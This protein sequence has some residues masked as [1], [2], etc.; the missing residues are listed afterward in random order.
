MVCFENPVSFVVV[1]QGVIMPTA[2]FDFWI[3]PSK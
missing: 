3:I 2:H 1:A